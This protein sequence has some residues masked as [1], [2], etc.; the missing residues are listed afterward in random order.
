MSF[1]LAAGRSETAIPD[2]AGPS[3]AVVSGAAAGL[4]AGALDA[5]QGWS[6][7]S[8]TA[9]R[10]LLLLQ[11]AGRL[12]PIGLCIAL[13]ASVGSLAGARLWRR[14]SRRPARGSSWALTVLAL[15]ACIYVA[16]RLFQGGTTSRL[17]ARWLLVALAALLLAVLTWIAASVVLA[18]VARLDRPNAARGARLA[19]VLALVALALGA[20]WCDGHLYR[21]LYDY[22]HAALALGSLGLLAL[23]ARIAISRLGRVETGRLAIAAA[24]TAAL[25]LLLLA[26][27]LW[28][29]NERQTVK[30]ALHERTAT[31]SSLLR[32]ASIVASGKSPAESR[33]STA[34]R[35]RLYERERAEREVIS[36]GDWPTFPGAHLIIISIDALRADRLGVYGY[37]ERPASPR[38][39]EWASRATAFER[40]YCPVPH[41][42]Y[43]IS[44]FHTSRY[45]YDEVAMGLDVSSTT[46]MADVLGESGYESSAFYTN[47]IFHTHGD[48]VGSLR[49]RSFGFESVH[50]GSPSPDKLADLAITRIESYIEQG[51]PAFFLWV[52]FFNVHEPYRSERFGTSPRERYEGEIFEADAAAG[53]LLD[54]VEKELARDA[55]V[56]LT[57]D[58]GEE[59]GE[60]GGHYHGSSLYEEQV[61]VPLII[62]VPGAEPR[63]VEQPVSTLDTA[64][65]LLRLVGVDVPARMEGRDLRPFLLSG[66]SPRTPH[67][68]FA[69]VMR[70]HMAVRWPWK[71]ISDPSRRL[72]EL[73]DLGSD[74]GEKRNLYDREP[75]VGAELLDEIRVWIDGIAAA[76]DRTRRALRLGRLRDPRAVPTLL[77]VARDVEAQSRDRCEALELVGEIGV[78]K[79]TGEIAELLGD[80]DRDVALAAAVALGRLGSSRG[81]RVLR[82]ALGS[83]ETSRRDRAALALANLGDTA[84]VPALIEALHRGD[85]ELRTA[86]IRHLGR[87]GDRR[88]F[89]PLVDLLDD[90]RTRYRTVKALGLLGDPRAG[91]VLLD[92][93]ASDDHTDTRCYAVQSLGRLGIEWAAPR[94]LRLLVE[95]PELECTAESLVRIGAVGRAPLFGTDLARGAPSLVSG[96]ARCTA[97]GE[98]RGGY[99]GRTTCLSSGSRAEL[100]FEAMADR[101]GLLLVRAR[102]LGDDPASSE[103]LEVRI[104]GRLAATAELSGAMREYRFSLEP[105]LWPSGSL[106]ISLVSAGGERFEVDH[107]LLLGGGT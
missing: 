79:K 80:G 69:S 90:N 75:D 101:G 86:A 7:L 54:H 30:L 48:R 72:F 13:V 5:V 17:P 21:R 19:A 33:P 49:D 91:A 83:R 12:A 55:V 36:S 62:R 95:E 39:D 4:I 31:T 16:V 6:D 61:R 107:I 25:V 85:L 57:A 53:R 92:V 84:A 18:L 96:W 65:T 76:A 3:L 52:H 59:F 1:S 94:L 97:D 32:V 38:I 15:P 14:R 71:L 81:A 47:G 8:G 98:G 77:D 34:A 45:L 78:R 66:Q 42:S 28:T 89:E 22:L 102:H 58:H 99:L 50:H 10:A 73:Y 87:L 2:F 100:R 103:K 46:T 104:D 37:H 68:V 29:S 23:G 20:R 51:E 35:R 70:Q 93:L 11:T 24:R 40:A 9:Q 64:P 82:E 106:P 88:A 41:S 67:P 44:S 43:S 60:H 26:A 63:F 27:A 74:P 56:V 105:G